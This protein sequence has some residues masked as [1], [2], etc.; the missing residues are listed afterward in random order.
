MRVGISPMGL[1]PA[2]ARLSRRSG[3]PPRNHGQVLQ[4]RG[5]RP[6]VWAVPRSLAATCGISV[7]FYSSGYLDVSL[8]LVSPLP[9]MC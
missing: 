2:A 9:P 3:Y 5:T 7:D 4:P 8:P 6:A 1:S